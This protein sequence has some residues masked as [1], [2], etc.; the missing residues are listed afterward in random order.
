MS[1]GGGCEI[2]D[3]SFCAYAVRAFDV[4]RPAREGFSRS[5]NARTVV[6]RSNGSIA[7]AEDGVEP[8][9]DDEREN[10]VVIHRHTRRGTTRLDRGH[11]VD[12]DSLR[13]DGRKL[14]WRNGSRVRRATLR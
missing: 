12:A 4:R 7:W 8:R 9:H 5:A 13:L 1:V 10:I 11:L 3:P 14:S 6:L 2:V